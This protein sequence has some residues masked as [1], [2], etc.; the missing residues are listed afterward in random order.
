[1]GYRVSKIKKNNDGLKRSF[2]FAFREIHLQGLAEK[3]KF[4]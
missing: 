4:C 3:I 2:P 1:V